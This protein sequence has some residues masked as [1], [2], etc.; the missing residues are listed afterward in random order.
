M[1]TIKTIGV[2]ILSLIGIIVILSL[3]FYIYLFAKSAI[4]LNNTNETIQKHIESDKAFIYFEHKG[5]TGIGKI[6]NNSKEDEPPFFMVCC[7][8]MKTNATQH[9]EFSK[10]EKYVPIKLEKINNIKEDFLD[11]IPNLK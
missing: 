9:I 4:I 10:I 5:E 8:Y 7:I 3:I 2:I 1:E 11:L 6:Y